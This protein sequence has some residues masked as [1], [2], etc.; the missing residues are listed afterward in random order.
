MGTANTRFDTFQLCTIPRQ[1]PHAKQAE[2]KVET[3]EKHEYQTD[4]QSAPSYS[5][6]SDHNRGGWMYIRSAH[7]TFRR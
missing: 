3:L 4:F 7:S 5:G 6:I 2:R 1:T